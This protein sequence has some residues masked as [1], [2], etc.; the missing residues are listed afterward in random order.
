MPEGLGAYHQ[1]LRLA[2]AWRV[3]GLGHVLLAEGMDPGR[4]QLIAETLRDATVKRL[5]PDP[6]TRVALHRSRAESAPCH[7]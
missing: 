5:Q 3:G 2:Y 4:F 6:R 7:A 1:G